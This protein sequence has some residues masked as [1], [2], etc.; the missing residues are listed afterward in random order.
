MTN[1]DDSDIHLQDDRASRAIPRW[2]KVSVRIILVLIVL[3][4]IL[5]LTGSMNMHMPMMHGAQ[6]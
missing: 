3:F 1:A 6:P 5:H 4:I 2:V